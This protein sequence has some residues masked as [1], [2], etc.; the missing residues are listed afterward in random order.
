R[1]VLAHHQRLLLFAALLVLVPACLAD[2]Q[3]LLR[4]GGRRLLRRQLPRRTRGLLRGGVLLDRL[5]P[6]RGRETSAALLHQQRIHLLAQAVNLGLLAPELL[7][8]LPEQFVGGCIA[9][10]IRGV[11][12]A[13]AERQRDGEEQRPGNG[14]RG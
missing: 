7:A 12:R 11:G 5:R 6:G 10:G 1:R 3:R 8:H 4:V 9:R 2:L 14:R 13:A